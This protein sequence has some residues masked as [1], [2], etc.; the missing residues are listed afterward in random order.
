VVCRDAMLCV[1]VT[2][3]YD[4]TWDCNAQSKDAKHCVSTV[5]HENCRANTTWECNAQSKDAKHC[6]STVLH[7]NCRANTTWEYNAQSKDAKHCVS[8]VLHMNCR[9]FTTIYIL[10]TLVNPLLREVSPSFEKIQNDDS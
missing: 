4:A 6:V 9:A 1:F 5:L 2:A 10:F 8:A 7:E 3:S